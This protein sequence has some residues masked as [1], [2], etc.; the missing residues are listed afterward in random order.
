MADTKAVTV[1]YKGAVIAAINAGGAKAIRCKDTI[2]QDDIVIDVPEQQGGEAKLQEKTVTANG[3]VLPD[4]EYD[5]LSK[6]TVNVPA[7]IPDGYIKPSGTKAITNNGTHDVSS[8]ASAEVNVPVGVF[9]AGTK[10]I[11]ANGT[12]DVTEFASV[13]VNVPAPVLTYYDGSVDISGG[14]ELISFSID[15]TT[16]QAED[17]M[18]WYD[19]CNSSYNTIDAVVL[20]GGVIFTPIG[21]NGTIRLNGTDVYD[22]DLIIAEALYSIYHGSGGAE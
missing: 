15:G 13:E 6:V 7:Q 4:A 5:G 17:G 16:Y 2:L 10:E 9:P 3:E 1:E 18:T 12:H 8:F 20:A 14:V 11:T 22:T 21:N 19:W